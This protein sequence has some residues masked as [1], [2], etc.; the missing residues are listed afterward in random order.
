MYNEGACMVWNGHAFSGQDGIAAFLTD[1]PN[2][3]HK[4]KSLDAQAITNS[5]TQNQRTLLL[6]SA[7]N[8][9]FQDRWRCFTETFIITEIGGYWKIAS[10]RFRFID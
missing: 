4:I 3:D 2:S 10:D 1:L 5:V 9:K 7:G 8:I 6:N